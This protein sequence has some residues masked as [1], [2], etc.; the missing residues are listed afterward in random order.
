MNVIEK[1]QSLLIILAIGLGL[2]LGQIVMIERHAELFI[3]PLLIAM[4]YGLFLSIPLK[5]FLSAFQHRRFLGSSVFLNF[6][7][8]PIFAWVLG[9]LFLA[10]HPALWLGF[11]LLLVTPCTDWY[12]IFTSIAKGNVHLSTS[13]LPV[14]LLL[15]VIL[16][17]LYLLIFAG[18][19]EMVHLPTIL[20]SVLFVL[21][22]PFIL[23]TLTRLI[24][25]NRTNFLQSK[26]LPFFST[27]QL[28]FLCLAIVAMF[29]SQGTYLMDNLEVLWLLLLP[30]LLF[31]L[32]NFFLFPYLLEDS[33]FSLRR[34]RKF[35]L[36]DHCKKLSSGTCDCVSRFSRAATHCSCTHYWSAH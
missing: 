13:V 25:R 33:S 27:A 1:Y 28:V 35:K 9:A 14:N 5:G 23:A 29:A 2:L 24:F 11:I 19:M 30:L 17:P 34:H 4:L 16:L 12:L 10:D 7:W 21:F 6:V 36:D 15:Q 8:T 20:E 18:T 31:F 26:V 32:I 22:L 3:L